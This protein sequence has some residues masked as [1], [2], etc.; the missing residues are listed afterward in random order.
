MGHRGSARHLDKF[1]SIRQ[2]FSDMA[3]LRKISAFLLVACLL[4]LQPVFS[5][6][7]PAP[8]YC[9]HMGYNYSNGSCHFSENTSCDGEAFLDGECGEEFQKNISCRKKSEHVFP[10]F[11]RCCEDMEPH[12]EPGTIGQPT[13]Q[14]ENSL[15]QEV[16]L[17]LGS[18][19]DI[20]I[21]LL[22]EL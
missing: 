4:M 16:S 5:A 8:N 13:C 3:D 2:K 1:L 11:E 21:D 20:F 14:P 22:T 12:I 6:M 9:E 18:V 17:W 15:L 19:S 7:P 10:E